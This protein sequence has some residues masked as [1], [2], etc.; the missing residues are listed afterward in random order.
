MPAKAMVPVRALPC[1]HRIRGHGPLLQRVMDAPPAAELDCGS[2]GAGHAREG[3]D[4][5][6]CVCWTVARVLCAVTMFHRNASIDTS[7]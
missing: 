3:A 1:I 6:R 2:V 5:G 4:F 7:T